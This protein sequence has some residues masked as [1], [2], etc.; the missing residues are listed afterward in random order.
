LSL[1][2]FNANTLNVGAFQNNGLDSS[3]FSQNFLFNQSTFDFSSSG[4]LTSVTLSQI[5]AKNAEVNFDISLATDI[6]LN[7]SKTIFKNSS[8][9]VRLS[10]YDAAD[11]LIVT[12]VNN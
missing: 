11:A 12:N 2:N 6:Y 5:E 4:T 8:Q 1:S 9:V 10:Y 3:N 7:C